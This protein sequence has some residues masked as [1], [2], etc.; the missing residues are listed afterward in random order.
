MIKT[1]P[2]VRLTETGRISNLKYL[3]EMGHSKLAF[4]PFGWGELCFRDYEAVALGSL[5]I[6]PSM[7]HLHTEPNIFIPFETYVPVKWDLSDLAELCTH[8]L[9]NPEEAKQI[10]AN[11]SRAFSDYFNQQQFVTKIQS[12][13]AKVGLE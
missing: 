13:L 1:V 4:S 8:Y 9:A 7:E 6:K 10:I 12:V 2:S 3:D 5:L 11:A